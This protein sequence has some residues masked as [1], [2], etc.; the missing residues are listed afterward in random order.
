MRTWWEG[1]FIPFKPDPLSSLPSSWFL[2]T[3]NKRK[4]KSSLSQTLGVQITIIQNCTVM[5]DFNCAC[6][7]LNPNFLIN[8]YFES[9]GTSHIYLVV[10]WV[11]I[12][13]QTMPKG[14]YLSGQLFKWF[15]SSFGPHKGHIFRV[16]IFCMKYNFCNLLWVYE[17]KWLSDTFDLWLCSLVDGNTSWLYY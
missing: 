5:I 6:N 2:R 17:W 11:K 15:Y 10:F 7:E 14:Y 13:I 3:K 8:N 9:H 16:Q 4:L 12:L 1:G